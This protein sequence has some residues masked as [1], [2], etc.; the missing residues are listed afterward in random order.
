MKSNLDTVG[1]TRSGVRQASASHAAVAHP[2]LTPRCAAA[3]GPIW[4]ASRRS[5]PW[6]LFFH[7]VRSLRLSVSRTRPHRATAPPTPTHPPRGLHRPRASSTPA[8]PAAWRLATSSAATRCAWSR[9]ERPLPLRSARCD[10]AAQPALRLC[11]PSDA[12]DRRR[13]GAVQLLPEFEA[14]WADCAD[15]ASVGG[16]PPSLWSALFRGAAPVVLLT[17]A[18]HAVSTARASRPP[19]PALRALLRCLPR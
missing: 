6:R 1:Y 2:V 14:A 12:P 17:A 5:L 3:G 8:T 11:A 7:H 15:R 18:L 16:G 4:P 10:H 13:R 19:A 9:R